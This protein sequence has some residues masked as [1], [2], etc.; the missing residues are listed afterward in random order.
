VDISDPCH[1]VKPRVCN[2]FH[3]RILHDLATFLYAQTHGY[4]HTYLYIP[5]YM[6]T[7][8]D[9]KIS[10]NPVWITGACLHISLMQVSEVQEDMLC[11]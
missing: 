3:I 11:T 10:A 6:F 9:M 5:K 2:V 8:V 4:I 7:C 1:Q